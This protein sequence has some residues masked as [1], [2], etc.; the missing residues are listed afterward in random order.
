MTV[1]LMI[2]LSDWE[3]RR[4]NELATL[5]NRTPGETLRDAL[6]FYQEHGQGYQGHK[7]HATW[8]VSHMLNNEQRSYTQI[9]TIANAEA[10]VY[11]AA[12]RLKTWFEAQNSI[13]DDSTV[14][15]ALLDSILKDID[16]VSIA[17]GAREEME[18][19]ASP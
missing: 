12:D 4:L 11:E 16:W 17:E 15:S 8:I 19:D 1:T 10:D 13:Q 2:N 7:N 6:F 5:K 3:E 14:W 9:R 18:P